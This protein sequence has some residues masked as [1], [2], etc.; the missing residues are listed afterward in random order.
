[1]PEAEWWRDQ[2]IYQI[3]PRSFQDSDA[4]GV[5]DLQGIIDRLDY[6]NDSSKRSLR[7]GGIWLTPIYPSP[8]FDF[9]YDVADY[10]DVDP[11]YGTLDDFD[12]LVQEAEKRGIR[13]IMDLVSNHTSHLHPWFQES[14]SSRDNPKRDWYIWRDARTGEA[15]PNNWTSV[16]FGRAWEWDEQT[17]Q[18]YCHAFLKEQPDLNWQNPEVRAAI[19][20]AMRFWMRRGVGGFRLDA[21]AHIGKH[22]GLPDD[23]FKPG[24][25][26]GK[27]PEW[28]DQIHVYDLADPVMHPWLR[29][30]RTVADEFGALLVGE[31][32][33][34][35][36]D[37][38]AAFTANNELHSVFNFELLLSTWHAASFRAAVDSF[39]H[40]FPTGVWPSPVIDN[41]DNHRSFS[42]WDKPGLGTGR[43][44]VAAMLLL[45]LRGTPYLYY[46]QEIGMHDVEIRSGQLR[47]PAANGIVAKSRDPE[48]TPMQWTPGSNAGFSRAQPWLPVAPDSTSVNVETESADPTSVLTLYRKLTSLRH[49]H[50]ALREGSYRSIDCDAGEVY[51]YLRESPEE[52]I[53]AILN[54]GETAATVDISQTAGGGR[55]L[56]ATGGETGGSLD[57]T[58]V[59]LPSTS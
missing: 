23:P 35:R 56:L 26:V 47:D 11:A 59:E 6:L 16:F 28:E 54:F 36:P 29:E 33:S 55:V 15:Y 38:L 24:V 53:L 2:I 40:E 30:L 4:D 8:L 10:V 12:R 58:A 13:V 25:A 44:K 21:I 20:E 46:G 57:V 7:V 19:A 22:P 17:E 45:T 32:Y 41:H 50:V 5:G 1:M 9:G 18:F 37:S 14:R 43:A 31:I 49:E 34:L 42:R 39:E 51:G 27:E 3:Y 48:R 52:R